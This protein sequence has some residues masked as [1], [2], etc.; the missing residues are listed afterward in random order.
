MIITERTILNILDHPFD[1]KWTIQ[2][3]GMLRTYLDDEQVNRLHL[4]NT[5]VANPNVSTIHDHA[6]DFDSRI[7]HGSMGNRRYVAGNYAD[8]G[9]VYKWAKIRAGEGGGIISD[10]DLMAIK[11]KPYEV[12]QAGETYHQD[13]PELHE[14]CPA[15]GTVTVITRNFHANRD[16]ATVCWREGDWVTAEPRPATQQEIEHFI[17]VAKWNWYA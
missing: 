11:E 1:Y 15:P 10:P 16:I 4:W 13:A 9:K 5:D 14:S 6:W 7:V 2:G 8:G 17:R 12:Y 3:F